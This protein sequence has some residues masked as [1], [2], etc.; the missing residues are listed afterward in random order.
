MDHFLE[1]LKPLDR[2]GELTICSDQDL[3]I[4]DDWHQHIQAHLNGAKAAVLLVSPAFLASDY[5]AN[6]ELPILLKNASDR[7]V[8]I[9]PILVSPSAFVWAKYKYPDP[10]IGPEQFTLA[11]L[12]TANP[13]S[14]T[15]VEMTEGEQSRVFEGVTKRLLEILKQNP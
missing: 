5:I 4:G 14:K 9:L 2:Q 3:K 11:S 13:P 1:F 7:G 15:L 12:Q 6:N 10:R 8:R